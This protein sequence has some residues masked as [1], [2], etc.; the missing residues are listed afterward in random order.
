MWYVVFSPYILMCFPPRHNAHCRECKMYVRVYTS[1]LFPGSLMILF[2]PVINCWNLSQLNQHSRCI[3]VPF[4]MLALPRALPVSKSDCFWFSWCVP[5]G[6]QL[7]F[8]PVK[9]IHVLTKSRCIASCSFILPLYLSLSTFS[10]LQD[11]LFQC[12]SRTRFTKRHF[13]LFKV[14]N[15]QSTRNWISTHS[16]LLM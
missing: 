12:L 13:L 14:L 15:L 6:C 7:S 10:S 8:P 2:D 1:N 9:C 5:E 11:Y 4:S 16:A 3:L